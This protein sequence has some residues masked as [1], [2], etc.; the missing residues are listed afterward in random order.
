MFPEL[1]QKLQEAGVIINTAENVG[2]AMGYLASKKVNGKGLYCAANSWWELED[3][4]RLLEPQWLGE[5]NC[6]QFRKA[7]STHFFTSKSGL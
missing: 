4:L 3:Q 2:L 6:E 7:S 1:R 5:R